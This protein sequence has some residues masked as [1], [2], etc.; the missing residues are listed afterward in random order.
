MRIQNTKLQRTRVYLDIDI[1]CT[2]P[3]S[4]FSQ[5]KSYVMIMNDK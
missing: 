4:L 3:Y 5:K 1:D 2:F